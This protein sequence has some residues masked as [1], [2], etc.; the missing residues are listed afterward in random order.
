LGAG[1]AGRALAAELTAAGHEVIAIGRSEPPLLALAAALG[2]RVLPRPASTADASGLSAALDG[3]ERVVLL[4]PP[5]REGEP[6]D[7]AARVMAALPRDVDRVVYGSTTGVFRIPDDPAV[8]VDEDWPAG[9]R[10]RRGRARLAY[11]QA[12]MATSPGPVHTVRIAGIYGPGRTLAPKLERGELVLF[13]GGPVTSRIHRDDLARLLAAMVL[14]PAPPPRVVATDEAPAPTLEVARFTA[15]LMGLPLPPVL[16]LD[17]ASKRLSPAALELR[18]GG[19]RCRSL[20]R[21]SLIGALR[22][23]SYREGVRAALREEGK[24]A[25][26]A[27]EL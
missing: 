11:E 8:W 22:Y 20:H 5:P 3:A 25:P 26:D 15:E 24:L 9:P 16:S 14:D 21:P 7:D 10:G 27:P 17:E 13:E 4:A 12:L 2:E 23:P 18:M 19:K 6:E 1:Y